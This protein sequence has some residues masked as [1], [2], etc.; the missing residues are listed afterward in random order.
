MALPAPF[1]RTIE[2]RLQHPAALVRAVSSQLPRPIIDAL[3]KPE[4]GEILEAVYFLL[5]PDA[6]GLGVRP[7]AL[8]ADDAVLVRPSLQG[9][10]DL[11]PLLAAD[12][13]LARP[14]HLRFKARPQFA[15]RELLA[16]GPDAFAQVVAIDLKRE[17]VLAYAAYQ[18]MEAR[19]VGVVMIDC[20]PFK[21]GSEVLLHSADQLANMIAKI[22]AVG[23]FRRDDEAPHQLVAA[24]FP[25]PH[26]RDQVDSLARRVEAKALCELL[27]RSRTREV[28][29]VRSPRAASAVARER[30]L[31]HAPASVSTKFASA[32]LAPHLPPAKTPMR[33]PARAP[34]KANAPQRPRPP[35]NHPARRLR[36]LRTKPDLD[37]FAPK[38]RPPH[39]SPPKAPG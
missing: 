33:L 1:A 22:E 36:R 24:P 30:R 26:G 39:C 38:T 21:P 2:P 17:S 29:R 13:P 34:R 20:D 31:D 37:L 12:D 32:A 23:V 7:E 10:V 15:R 35:R 11:R 5:R 4:S 9:A 27:L 6:C 14:E 28:L 25:R 19:L 3:R 18:Q 8:V 16:P